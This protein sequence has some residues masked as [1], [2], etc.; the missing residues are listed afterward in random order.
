LLRETRTTAI[1][2][3]LPEDVQS[4]PVPLP[5]RYTMGKI[6]D[7]VAAGGAPVEGHAAFAMR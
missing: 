2:R 7:N 3:R 6:S 5:V 4:L 1:D